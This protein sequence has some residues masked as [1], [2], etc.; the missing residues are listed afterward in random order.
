MAY[1]LPSEAKSLGGVLSGALP[2]IP[3]VLVDIISTFML[4]NPKHRD[5]VL[6]VDGENT[7]LVL[8]CWY[9]LL[10]GSI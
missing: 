8:L 10:C 5:R 2:Q 4:F 1:I 9:L 6:A 7:W 3:P